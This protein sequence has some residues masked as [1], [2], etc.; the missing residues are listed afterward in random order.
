MGRTLNKSKCI[1]RDENLMETLTGFK[2]CSALIESKN[3]SAYCL[4]YK[5]WL[6][7]CPPRCPFFTEGPPAKITEAQQNGYKLSCVKCTRVPV[8]GRMVF[9]CDFYEEANPDC[10][11]CDLNF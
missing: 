3:Q 8:E 5:E 11:N 4:R 2:R 7:H 9:Y 10:R 6:D 1:V